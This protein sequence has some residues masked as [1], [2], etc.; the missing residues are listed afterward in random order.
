MSSEIYYFSGTGNSLHIAKE[1]H[2][3][4]PETDLKPIVSLLNQDYT[5]TTGEIVGFIFPIH[6]AM[7][8][9]PV[10]M[11]IKKLDLKSTKYIYAI[12]TRSGSQHR[13]FIDLEKILNKKDK[14]FDSFFNLNM[15]SNDPKFENWHQATENEIANIELEVQK[16]LNNIQR[17]IINKEK[18]R[19]NDPN[20][21]VHMPMF[22]LLSPFLPIL[23]GL[24]S[25]DFYND[26]K[27]VGC[28]TCEK[29]CLSGKITINNKKPLWDK[30]ISCFFCHA[31]LNYCQEQAVQIKSTKFLKSFTD[32]NGR[33][34]HPDAT[35]EDIA[36]QKVI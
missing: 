21:T 15:A 6:L 26:S 29:V 28:G 10:K 8:P 25:V 2:K 23:N 27:C 19:E 33:Y 12:A 11:F 3:R 13:A 22:S 30:N 1:L 34:F 18:S 5:K 7:A 36:E 32:K 17:I 16:N 20:F 14:D 35:V 4:I 24:Y 9:Y 31:C